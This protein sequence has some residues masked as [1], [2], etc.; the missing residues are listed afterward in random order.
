MN[1]QL[2]TS[3]AIK[4]VSFQY[5]TAVGAGLFAHG[6]WASCLLPSSFGRYQNLLR[7]I[8]ID[9]ASLVTAPKEARPQALFSFSS[10]K[11]EIT[12]SVDRSLN[13]SCIF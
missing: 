1:Y 9:I 6:R 2:L 3:C 11:A 10:T 5:L 8:L 13:I 12:I 4:P 7:M